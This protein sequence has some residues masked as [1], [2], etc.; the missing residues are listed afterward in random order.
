M[1]LHILPKR[2]V[3]SLIHAEVIFGG[4]EPANM[5]CC[6][7]HVPF[8]F[9][10]SGASYYTHI[11][12]ELLAMVLPPHLLVRGTDS[13][14]PCSQPHMNARRPPDLFC[15]PQNNLLCLCPNTKFS[16]MYYYTSISSCDITNG[17]PRFSSTRSLHINLIMSWG[18]CIILFWGEKAKRSEQQSSLCLQDFLPAQQLK[19]LFRGAPVRA[20]NSTL[21]RQ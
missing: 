5:L 19:L 18:L 10:N 14:F 12:F 9:F 8:F 6:A 7:A 15:S 13:L 20:V 17:A 11:L 16:W 3:I 21:S 1:F 2:N 4:S